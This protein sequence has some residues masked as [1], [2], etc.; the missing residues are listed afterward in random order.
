VSAVDERLN[1]FGRDLIDAVARG[2]TD[3]YL[4]SR[5]LHYL[6]AVGA[7]EHIREAAAAL[8][9]RI[10]TADV[11]LVPH[12]VRAKSG[13]LAA[14][15]VYRR[16]ERLALERLALL[17]PSQRNAVARRLVA[18]VDLCAARRAALLAKRS[19]VPGVASWFD[20]A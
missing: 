12:K 3:A 13:S 11:P 17:T 7:V 20:A 8:G 10:P 2:D 18:D 14:F 1:P 16:A 15:N 5:E 6:A 19:P 9:V 4:A